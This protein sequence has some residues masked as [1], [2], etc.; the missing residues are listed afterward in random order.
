[1]KQVPEPQEL[2]TQEASRKPLKAAPVL[3][4]L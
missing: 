1:M 3:K 2:C 4:V